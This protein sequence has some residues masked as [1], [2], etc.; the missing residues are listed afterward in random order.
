MVHLRYVLLAGGVAFGIIPMLH[1]LLE[2]DFKCVDHVVPAVMSMFG[3]YLA[4]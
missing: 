4:G 1:L 2:C 3:L